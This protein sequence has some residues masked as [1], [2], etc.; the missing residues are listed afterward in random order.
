M[1]NSWLLGGNKDLFL[2][3]HVIVCDSQ[4][5]SQPLDQIPWDGWYIEWWKMMIVIG[6]RQDLCKVLEGALI[7]FKNCS[8]RLRS[9]GVMALQT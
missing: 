5:T 8:K 6:Y 9:E 4:P 7:S 3:N 1:L 2:T